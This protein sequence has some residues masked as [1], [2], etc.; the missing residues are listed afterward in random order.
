M[1]AQEGSQRRTQMSRLE[2]G[3]SAPTRPREVSPARPQ[4]GRAEE[5]LSEAAI[6]A[7]EEGRADH[8]AGRTF[9]LDEIKREFGIGS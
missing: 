5:E 7:I 8:A 6:R 1:I 9:T 4:A 2:E 3:R